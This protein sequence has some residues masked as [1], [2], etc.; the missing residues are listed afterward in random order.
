[1][2]H[3]AKTP[4]VLLTTLQHCQWQA[5]CAK[6]LTCAGDEAQCI[7]SRLHVL[8]EV[9]VGVVENVLMQVQVVEALGGQ[10]H[11]NIIACSHQQNKI[12]L[13]TTFVSR[14]S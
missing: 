3:Q 12:T 7:I 13:E 6:L 10:H 1:M 5:G 9:N 4:Q 8:P 14:V 2:V 11:A